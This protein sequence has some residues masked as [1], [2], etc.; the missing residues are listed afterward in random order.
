M[1]MNRV[2]VAVVG[3]MLVL[4]AGL[5]G[6]QSAAPAD[7]GM[8]VGV[9]TDG[10]SE[11]WTAFRDTA[12]KEAAAAGVS[13]DFR[14]LSPSTADQQRLVAAE[15]IT[16]GAKALAICP[17]D[18]AQQ[19][20]FLQEIAGKVP[21]VLLNRDAADSGRACFIGMDEKEAGKKL[22]E[23]VTKLVPPG[24]KLAALVKTGETA[25]E[26]AR[27]E[28]LN[29]GLAPGEFIID[30]IKADKGDRNLAWAGADELMSKRVEL[31]A[32]IAFE[33][34][35]LPALLRAATAR[36]MD[37]IVNLVGFIETPDMQEA[38][39][40]GRIQGVVRPDTEAQAKQTVAVL[41]GAGAK[42]P[43]FKL[44]ENGVIGIAPRI[45]MTPKPMSNQEKMD[46]LQIPRVL[47]EAPAP[48]RPSF[49]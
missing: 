34:Y 24:M 14:M 36:K 45:E 38:F 1:E 12:T 49:E 10:A 46:A 48:A 20:A 30:A 28:G 6:A 31:A 27:M 44:P 37:G 29:E 47:E 16:A 42:D 13:L 19:K 9:L 3:M 4:G 41:R 8:R 23:V 21:L 18:P 22:A 32:Y 26:K 2:L 33:P 11:T 5:A 17:I 35:Q 7:G 40:K 43:A 25:A 39:S 15:M